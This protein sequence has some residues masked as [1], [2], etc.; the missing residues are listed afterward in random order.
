MRKVLAWPGCVVCVVSY[1]NNAK[2]AKH[3]ETKLTGAERACIM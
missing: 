2:P 3:T 1:E